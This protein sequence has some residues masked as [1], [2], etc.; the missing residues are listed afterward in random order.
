MSNVGFLFGCLFQIAFL[1][2]GLFQLAAMMAQLEALWGLNFWLAVAVGAA[3]LMFVPAVVPFFSFFGA[4]DVWGW[5]WW[6]ALLFAAPFSILA[7]IM[8]LSGGIFGSIG[9]LTNRR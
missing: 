1:V 6:Q 2:L 5:E 4:R 7:I 8:M 9:R 3:I